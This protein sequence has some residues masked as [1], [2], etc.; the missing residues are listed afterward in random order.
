MLEFN[1]TG[2]GVAVDV[3]FDLNAQVMSMK[4]FEDAVNDLKSWESLHVDGAADHTSYDFNYLTINPDDE[5]DDPSGLDHMAYIISAL[6]WNCEPHQM[7]PELFLQLLYKSDKGVGSSRLTAV[8]IQR[9]D[10]DPRIIQRVAKRAMEVTIS[11][12]GPKRLLPQKNKAVAR[13]SDADGLMLR[14]DTREGGTLKA[15]NPIYGNPEPGETRHRL[16][17][18]GHIKSTYEQIV[19]LTGAVAIADLA[20]ES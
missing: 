17:A 14:V 11:Q 12:L 3:P 13:V 15:G 16:E 19:C 8:S 9:P 4:M 7:A 10:H 18:H 1:Y 2:S 5:V 6:S 20:R